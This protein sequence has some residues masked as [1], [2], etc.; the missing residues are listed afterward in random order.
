LTRQGEPPELGVGDVDGTLA[1]ERVGMD[2][3]N[4]FEQ[5]ADF[6][7]DE[8]KAGVVWLVRRDGVALAVRTAILRSSSKKRALMFVFAPSLWRMMVSPLTVPKA[9][10]SGDS[11]TLDAIRTLRSDCPKAARLGLM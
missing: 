4:E 1:F 5:L 6:V 7:S 8:G 2:V 3:G 9:Y 11:M 10:E